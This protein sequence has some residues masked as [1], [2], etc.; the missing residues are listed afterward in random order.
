MPGNSFQNAQTPQALYA[1]SA[2][3]LHLLND[4]DRSTSWNVSINPST[5]WDDLDLSGQVPKGTKALYGY[6]R[7]SNTDVRAIILIRDGNSATTDNF[8]TQSIDHGDGVND[9]IGYP[10][11][12]KAT[13]GEFSIKEYDGTFEGYAFNFQLW[14]WFI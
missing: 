6:M 10:A 12:I 14:G 13:D 1:A 5:S 2:G 7:V 11:I 8:Q 4:T 9:D 3:T